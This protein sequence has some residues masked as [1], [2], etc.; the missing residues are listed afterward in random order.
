[1]DPNLVKSAPSKI[2]LVDNEPV[3]LV[4]L[5]DILSPEGF[6]IVEAASGVEAIE[7]VRKVAID[8]ILC[9]VSMPGM[10]G[11]DVCRILKAD[12]ATRYIPFIA[13]TG[14]RAMTDRI[15]GIES[16]ADDYLFKPVD[17]AE[18]LARIRSTLRLGAYRRILA[19][20]EK[21]EA[22][23]AQMSDGLVHLRGDGSVCAA[24]AAAIQL[25]DLP[26]DGIVGLDLFA[27]VF[28]RFDVSARESDLRK[29]TTRRVR[30]DVSRSS[31]G[32]SEPPL[33]LSAVLTRIAVAPG[34]RQDQ[35]L[36]VRN[37]TEEREQI[38]A[39]DRFIS[40]MSHKLRTPITILTGH[41]DL[42]ATESPDNLRADQ[43][44]SVAAVGRAAS[45]LHELFERIMTFVEFGAHDGEVHSSNESL[46][47][48][49]ARV[50]ALAPSWHSRKPITL[51][52]VEPALDRVVRIDTHLMDVVFNNLLENAVKFTHREAVRIHIEQV[53]ALADG[54]VA[55]AITDDGPGVPSE[56]RESVFR[57]FN[58]VEE[59][60]T[61]NVEGLGLGLPLAKRI[62]EKQ[63]G[64][65]R[66]CSLRGNEEGSG[67]SIVLELPTSSCSGANRPNGEVAV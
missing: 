15:R 24:N 54:C 26:D 23:M 46:K 21:F 57:G 10:T 43:Q 13:L 64:S 35:V 50:S 60:F 47:K 8:L 12:E 49:L 36:C 53:P 40:L 62:M 31:H 28:E 48:L 30:F 20:R 67:T 42:L 9:D 56:L 39:K 61:G 66:L 45:E 59:N 52:V 38:R 55:I 41:I 14:L 5:R 34:E 27:H 37:V 51:D 33:V 25:L 29:G 3:N 17:G 32:P 7:I 19:E 6:E 4:V 63:G 1:M 58:Q 16:G 65:I 11:L 22:A 44:E 2:L 18:V